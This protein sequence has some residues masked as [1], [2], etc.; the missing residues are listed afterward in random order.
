MTLGTSS[1]SWPGLAVI[2]KRPDGMVEAELR[3]VEFGHRAGAGLGFDRLFLSASFRKAITTADGR[4]RRSRLAPPEDTARGMWLALDHLYPGLVRDFGAEDLTIG[5]PECRSWLRVK[6]A[7]TG[8]W[9]VTGDGPRDIWAE[10]QNAAARWRAAGEP[11][12]Y[13]LHLGPDGVQRATSPNGT[14]TWQLPRTP[15]DSR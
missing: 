1:P 14:L 10:I 15:G 4:T 2:D 11:A 7:G 13:R 12:A 9:D 6:E 3:A 5:A 8:R